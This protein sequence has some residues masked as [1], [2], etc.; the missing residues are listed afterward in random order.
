MT[1]DSRTVASRRI[2][3]GC[4]ALTACRTYPVDGGK[5]VRVERRA[6]REDFWLDGSHYRGDGPGYWVVRSLGSAFHITSG[7]DDRSMYDVYHQDSLIPL[8]DDSISERADTQHSKSMQSPVN[9]LELTQ[10]DGGVL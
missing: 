9:R 1:N 6:P 10:Q 4:L 5:I 8:G 7:E 2:T 3:A